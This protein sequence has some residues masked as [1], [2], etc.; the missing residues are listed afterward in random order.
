MLM[1]EYGIAFCPKIPRPL[2]TQS[3]PPVRCAEC[4][5]ESFPRFD[6]IVLADSATGWISV[7]KLAVC[8]GAC[9]SPRVGP[10]DRCEFGGRLEV[11]T[12]RGDTCKHTHRTIQSVCMVANSEFVQELRYVRL[13]S[14]V[15]NRGNFEHESMNAQTSATKCAQGN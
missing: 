15:S 13:L 1:C 5:S 9:L 4:H 2:A 12:T 11:V 6:C 14:A 7:G 8:D 3:P 10:S